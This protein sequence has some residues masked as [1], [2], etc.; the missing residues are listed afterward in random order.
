M[1]STT[2]TGTVETGTILD[3]IIERTAADVALR[4]QIMSIEELRNQAAASGPAISLQSALGGSGLSLIA[5]IKRASPSK[6]RFPVEID[7]T[8]VAT[9][10]ATS[11][12]D[13]ISVLTDAP[14]FQGSLEDLRATTSV[15]HVAQAPIPV[16]RKDFIID[17]YQ[18]VEARANGAD[19]TLL[20]VG[21]LT[22]ERLA[23]LMQAA[24]ESGIETLV[25]VHDGPEMERALKAGASLIGINNR[26][27]H[28]FHVDLAVTER[29][30]P[31]VPEDVVLVG[32]SGIFTSED[33]R[34]MRFAGMDAVLVGESLIVA[35]DRA[36]AIGQIKLD[37]PRGTR[38]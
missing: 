21:A 27:L 3:R 18:L 22:D 4:K 16:L 10:Y 34:R 20:I 11:G 2:T 9:C 35:P 15:A 31:M 12:V 33:A 19:A 6:G 32:E 38:A 25:E 26:D 30:A 28:T 29:L 24:S 5:E 14:F 17:E 8:D 1:A 36:H 13:A 23:A 37:E 7:V